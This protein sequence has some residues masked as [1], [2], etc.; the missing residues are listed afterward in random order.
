MEEVYEFL[1]KNDSTYYLATADADGKPHVRPFGTID[2]YNGALH[3]D[4]SEN[5]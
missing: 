1:K 3:P 4:R 2:L 5:R